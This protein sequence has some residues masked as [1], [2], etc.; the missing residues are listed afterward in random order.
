M[1]LS[2]PRRR[3]ITRDAWFVG[4]PESHVGIYR[5]LRFPQMISARLRSLLG[6]ARRLRILP[7]CTRR[8]ALGDILRPS[9]R[10][11][12]PANLLHR[13]RGLEH[14][15]ARNALTRT[16]LAVHFHSLRRLRKSSYASRGV[17]PTPRGHQQTVRPASV[18]NAQCQ[19]PPRRQMCGKSLYTPFEGSDDA[20]PACEKVPPCRS[21]DG[22]LMVASPDR[23]EPL[24]PPPAG[25]RRRRQRPADGDGSRTRPAREIAARLPR[26]RFRRCTPSFRARRPDAGP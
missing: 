20:P 18:P 6:R 11:G 24:T 22:S 16:R 14:G 5:R 2:A 21:L 15:L 9:G 12:R 19:F 3:P 1:P 13:A 10:A 8:I 23:S 7:A 26:L 25:I 17:S 4:I